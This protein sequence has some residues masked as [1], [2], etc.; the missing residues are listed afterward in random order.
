VPGCAGCEV[1]LAEIREDL[2]TLSK[3]SPLDA[4]TI[5]HARHWQPALKRALRVQGHVPVL[6]LLRGY[7]LHKV[8]VERSC[9][10]SESAPPQDGS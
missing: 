5:F 10:E 6:R 7:R 9:D 4:E 3:P 8:P 1:E 2:A